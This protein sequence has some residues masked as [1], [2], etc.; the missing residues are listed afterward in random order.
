MIYC[1][2]V[3][4]LR[5]VPIE[6]AWVERSNNT[7]DINEVC[8]AVLDDDRAQDSCVVR[9]TL[10]LEAVFNNIDDLVDDQPNT[11]IL[12]RVDHDLNLIVLF[13]FHAVAHA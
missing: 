10:N 11:A 9:F 1:S 12:V 8:N 7:F 13:L 2:V 5:A 6:E 3:I 4:G